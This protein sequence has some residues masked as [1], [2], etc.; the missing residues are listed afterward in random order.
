MRCIDPYFTAVLHSR[1]KVLALNP[2]VPWGPTA[3]NGAAVTADNGAAVG[4]QG[5]VQQRQVSSNEKV[6]RSCWASDRK[7][8]FFEENADLLPCCM[9]QPGAAMSGREADIRSLGVL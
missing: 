3:D 7:G 8:H 2:T 1:E 4:A 6:Q 9:Q 5:H